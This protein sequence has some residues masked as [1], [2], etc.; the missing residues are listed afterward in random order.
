MGK[1]RNG[2]RLRRNFRKEREIKVGERAID[3]FMLAIEEAEA[4]EAIKSLEEGREPREI[5][6]CPNCGKI[7]FNAIQKKSDI[8]AS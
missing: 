8:I 6:V 1:N 2:R 3:V 4:D 5:F 7:D